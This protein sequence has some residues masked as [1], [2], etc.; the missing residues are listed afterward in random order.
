MLNVLDEFSH[1][2][3]ATFFF[4][5]GVSESECNTIFEGVV[6]CGDYKHQHC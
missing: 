5:G 3:L 2:C 1:E 4:A 6:V